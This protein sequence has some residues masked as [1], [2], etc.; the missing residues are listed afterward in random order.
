LVRRPLFG[1]FY[2]TGMIDGEEYG[3]VGGIKIGRGN[4]STRRKPAP[5]PLCSPQVP[6]DL[7]LNPG[8]RGGKPGINRLS[9]GTATFMKLIPYL[10]AKFLENQK[11]SS[12]TICLIELQVA[13]RMICAG[14]HFDVQ[15]VTRGFQKLTNC[16]R[17]FTNARS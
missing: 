10:L 15:R 17:T 8:R 16:N 11:T 7:G 5:A 4:R 3:A 2:Q 1:L 12:I 6:L 14:Y 9:C 13:L